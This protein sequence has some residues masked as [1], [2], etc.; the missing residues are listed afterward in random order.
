MKADEIKFFRFCFRFMTSHINGNI[1]DG[2]S[3]RIIIDM[4]SDFIPYKRCWYYL[5]KW[6]RIGFYDYGVTLDLGWLYVNE[7]PERYL[8]VLDKKGEDSNG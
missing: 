6:S 7:I 1:I 3:P 5:E 8:N 2:L 4:L